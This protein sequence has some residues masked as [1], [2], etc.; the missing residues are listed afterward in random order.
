MPGTDEA[1]Q[2][3]LLWTW[4]CYL[5]WIMITRL[6]RHPIAAYARAMRCPVLASRMAVPVSP[7]AWCA[8][9]GTER[10]LY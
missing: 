2:G 6:V 3:I 1:K 9:S 8:T 10:Q 4:T 5:S 7:G